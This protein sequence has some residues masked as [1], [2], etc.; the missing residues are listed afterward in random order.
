[1]TGIYG[2]SSSGLFDCFDP[3]GVYLRT[4]LGLEIQS[5]RKCKP[6]WKEKATGVGYSWW[7]LKTLE[8]LTSESDAGSWPTPAA[9][10]AD[11][12]SNGNSRSV[13]EAGFGI[14]LLGKAEQ[15][16]WPSPDANDWKHIGAANPG[17]TPQLRHHPL[18]ATPNV[19]DST[20]REYQVSKGKEVL[21]LPGQVKQAWA[22]PR[23]NE[24][25]QQNSQDNGMALSMEVQK[26]WYT[27]R[28]QNANGASERRGDLQG[29]LWSTPQATDAKAPSRPRAKKD[30][31]RDAAKQ[32]NYRKDLKD[33]AWPTP[34]SSDAD[35]WNA[36]TE[37][38]R[39]EKGHQVRLCNRAI[40]GHPDQGNNNN[41][42]KPRESLRLNPDWV[43]QLMG[44]P[45]GW[46]NTSD[47]DILSL[48]LESRKRGGK[49][50]A[51]KS[52]QGAGG[53]NSKHSATRSSR[54]APNSS[55][56]SS[57]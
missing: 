27:P 13:S 55:E 56:E 41:H 49:G 17:H 48:I 29:Q 50:T 36:Q 47:K 46:L 25:N 42:G 4:C 35:K 24:K 37:E 19:V 8:R 51:S 21:C 9:A 23:A 2:Q 15:Q 53:K 22:T 18:W 16:N 11:Q 34:N 44:F 6:I 40:G 57:K 1:M 30:H 31:K 45:D 28:A 52:K 43:S 3:I 7:V 14:N 26:D 5:F 38:E 32:G 33:I 20:L 54:N 10:N 12:G 39:K